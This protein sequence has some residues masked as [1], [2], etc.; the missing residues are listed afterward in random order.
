MNRWPST[1]LPLP[2]PVPSHH[3]QGLWTVRRDRL[4][5]RSAGQERVLWPVASSGAADP[6]QLHSRR[7][8]TSLVQTPRRPTPRHRTRSRPGPAS[9][10]TDLTQAHRTAVQPTGVQRRPLHTV[11]QVATSFGWVVGVARPTT[12]RRPWHISPCLGRVC[13]EGVGAGARRPVAHRRRARR[14]TRPWSVR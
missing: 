14:G 8:H 12:R 5:A 1:A 13:L 3:A 2:T 11:R 7:L 9:G 4:A 10:A 6:S